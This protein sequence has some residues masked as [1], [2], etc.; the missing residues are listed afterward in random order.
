[1][2]L[3][4][5]LE[6]IRNAS[7]ANLHSYA[8][9]TIL[10]LRRVGQR[11]QHNLIPSTPGFQATLTDSP[12]VPSPPLSPHLLQVAVPGRVPNSNSKSPQPLQAA[13]LTDHFE[14]LSVPSPPHSPQPFQVAG[15]TAL[16]NQGVLS[17][18]TSHFASLQVSTPT[19]QLIPIRDASRSSIPAESKRVLLPPD[20][21]PDLLK[22][23]KQS[24]SWVWEASQK[25]PSHL[26]SRKRNCDE[27]LRL[28]HIRRIDGDRGLGPEAKLLRLLALR[29]IALEFT[30]EQLDHEVYPTKLEEI[31]KHILSPT[32]S[33][34]NIFNY[35][36]NSFFSKALSTGLKHM[37]FEKI[38]SERL[39]ENDLPSICNAISAIA[40]LHIDQFRRFRY[41][42]MQG[43][44]DKL[45][46]GD[47]Y[48][49]IL[50]SK[51][52]LL[53][54][55]RD[56]SPWFNQLQN[57]YNFSGIESG[58]EKFRRT[59]NSAGCPVSVSPDSVPSNLEFT[60]I[61]DT[62]D[63]AE[64]LNPEDCTEAEF[65]HRFYEQ[66]SNQP[67][68]VSGIMDDIAQR[69]CFDFEQITP[70]HNLGL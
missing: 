70:L 62:D 41:D 42:E 33:E 58:R 46:S 65:A 37:V 5:A 22:R 11:L 51:I 35:G 39:K 8:A 27:D 68:D 38:I 48:V 69:S 9:Q 18:Q 23:I 67:I 28:E 7:D 44:A 53:D 40:G 13:G 60:N 32:S 4:V 15:T 36:N 43:F 30:N 1:M 50:Q 16:S 63:G 47:I 61:D 19:T 6:T 24:A 3:L 29:S 34:I 31:Y 25:L 64:S 49:T 21:I 14:T 66:I 20:H 56:L 52:H 55:V 45:I 57:S 10:T 17:P 59:D 2:D 12:S 54:L 26:L